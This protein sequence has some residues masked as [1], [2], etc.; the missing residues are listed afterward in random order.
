MLIWLNAI[1]L[2]ETAICNVSI[3]MLLVSTL[4]AREMG[5]QMRPAG[6]LRFQPPRTGFTGRN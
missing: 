5:A 1:T 2:F 3:E 6:G 4:V